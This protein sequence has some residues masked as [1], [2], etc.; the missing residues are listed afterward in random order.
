M[1]EHN[2]GSI[3]RQVTA[4]SVRIITDTIT[5][6]GD[7]KGLALIIIYTDYEFSCSNK[8]CWEFAIDAL[9]KNDPVWYYH[10][11]VWR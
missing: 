4:A 7:S 1:A 9:I 11:V 5:V 8:K 3:I 10:L 6:K 2:I